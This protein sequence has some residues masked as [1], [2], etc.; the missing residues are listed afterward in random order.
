[1]EVPTAS[2]RIPRLQRSVSFHDR[3]R[4]NVRPKD[5]MNEEDLEAEDDVSSLSSVCSVVSCSLPGNS[6][7]RALDCA[8]ES[9]NKSRKY[10]LHCSTPVNSDE[11]LTPTQRANSSSDVWRRFLR[12]R[13]RTFVT[14]ILRSSVWPGNWSNYGSSTAS[15]KEQMKPMPMPMP[16]KDPLH[17]WLI[18]DSSTIWFT[19][20]KQKNY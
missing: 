10:T 1:M 18:P 5:A 12:S 16:A 7:Q 2:S 14:R 17:R 8:S 9:R 20:T 13:K 3:V 4:R 11:Y 15:V 19:W 6:Y